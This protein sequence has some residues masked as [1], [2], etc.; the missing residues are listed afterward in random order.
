MLVSRLRVVTG[1]V[2]ATPAVVIALAAPAAVRA[3]AASTTPGQELAAALRTSPLYIDPSLRPAFPPAFRAQLVHEI[4][5]APAPVFI[6]AVRLSGRS[7][8]GNGDQLATVVHGY[9][10][11]PGIYLTLDAELSGEID[12]YTWPSDPYGAGAAPY[13]AADAALAVNLARATRD[14]AL[15]QKFL[16]CIELISAGQAV[17]AYQAALRQLDVLESA[18]RPRVRATDSSGSGTGLLVVL[19]VLL[20]IGLGLAGTGAGM[21]LQRHRQAQPSPGWLRPAFAATRAAPGSEP[22]RRLLVRVW[23]AWRRAE[24]GSHRR[25]P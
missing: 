5:K 11:R 21:W 23:P 14:A 16:R 2:L 17:P 18:P 10:G 8:W 1:L 20:M 22:V 25:L 4:S 9:L 3:A 6:L 13:H 15:P 12:A 19:I 7:E 24:R